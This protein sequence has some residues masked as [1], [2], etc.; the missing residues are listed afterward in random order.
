VTQFIGQPQLYVLECRL[1]GH[2]RA[3]QHAVAHELWAE[4]EHRWG[5]IRKLAAR[6]VAWTS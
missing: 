2:V 5:R 3:F 4:A 6:L 1:Q